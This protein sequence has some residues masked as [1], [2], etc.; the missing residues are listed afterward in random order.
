MKDKESSTI[1]STFNE[2]IE[3]KKT[4][5]EGDSVDN[6]LKA[7][8]KIVSS[9]KDG[10]KLLIC[11]NGGSAAD[12]QHLAAEFLIRLTSE[13][14]RKAL[15]AISLSQD[16]S[17]LTACVNDY[18]GEYIFS[19]TLSALGTSNDVLLV[20]TTS[21]NSENIIKALEKS[22]EMGIFSIGFLG[23]NGGKAIN[24]CNLSF[25]VPSSVTARIQ[26]SHITAGH[27]VLQYVEDQLFK[28]GFF[29]N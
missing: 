10:G 27:A 28:E 1:K 11:G 3:V 18:G 29:D 6:L 25:V 17:T 13:N 26:E 7:G 5:L 12:A 23:N 24:L 22:K 4:I 16:T 20:I 21:G 15:P 19:R 14:D 8:N 2:S 9:I